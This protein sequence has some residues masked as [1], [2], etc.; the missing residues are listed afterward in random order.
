MSQTDKFA[1]IINKNN[2][3]QDGIL[4]NT[5]IN[6]SISSNKYSKQ[7]D[8]RRKSLLFGGFSDMK[9]WVY[10]SKNQGVPDQ[11]PRNYTDTKST[12]EETEHLSKGPKHVVITTQPDFY[13]MHE[14]YRKMERI[15]KGRWYAF[16]KINKYSELDKQKQLDELDNIL[17]STLMD[18]DDY[19]N[20]LI[21]PKYRNKKDDIP[22]DNNILQEFLTQFKQ[23]WFD[24]ENWLDFKNIISSCKQISHRDQHEDYKLFNYNIISKYKNLYN[25]KGIL[26]ENDL[27]NNLSNNKMIAITKEDKGSLFCLFYRE[28]YKAKMEKALNCFNLKKLNSSEGIRL[29]YQSHELFIN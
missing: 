12:K 24:K 20:P 17:S 4:Y 28:Q 8:D 10:K 14:M 3:Q 29:L 2:I 5:N 21:P 7:V 16:R 15:V 9:S 18:D 13:E 25:Y 22:C 6:D 27:I 11:T 1:P 26:R 19:D 23:L